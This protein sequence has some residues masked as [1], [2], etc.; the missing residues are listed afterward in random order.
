MSAPPGNP[1]RA[2]ILKVFWP[3]LLSWGGVVA[4]LLANSW[5]T[6]GGEEELGPF[7]VGLALLGVGISLGTLG[8]LFV[9][10]KQREARRLRPILVNFGLLLII[11][12]VIILSWFL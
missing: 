2:G 11:V 1:P 6:A 8:A 10:W 5:P 9:T 3:G 7:F 12:F 4:S